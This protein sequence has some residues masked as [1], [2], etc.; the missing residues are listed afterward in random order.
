MN[1]QDVKARTAMLVRSIC[2]SS[3]RESMSDE[4]VL[5]GEGGVLDSVA[6]LELIVNIE[7]EFGITVTS[8]DI[9]P[10]NFRDTECLS[11]FI[12]RSLP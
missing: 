2:R 12:S 7:R 3:E 5:M 11:Q 10:E 6:M 9:C 1:P 8:E 4:F